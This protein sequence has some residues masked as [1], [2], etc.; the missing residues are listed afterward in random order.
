M[1]SVVS[2]SNPVGPVCIELQLD[3]TERLSSGREADSNHH[4]ARQ[5]D[6]AFST[7]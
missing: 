3:R 5:S 1:L 4:L 7:R 2:S 6:H